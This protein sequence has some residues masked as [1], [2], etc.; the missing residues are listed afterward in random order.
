MKDSGKDLDLE[1]LLLK[2]ATLILRAINHPLRQQ[3]LR[4]LH[5]HGKMTVTQVYVKLRLEQ[6]V[7]SQQLAILRH[8]DFVIAEREGKFVWYAINYTRLRKVQEISH[9]LLV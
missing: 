6:S 9:K 5:Q 7:A 4:L 1:L 3:I 2:N 8:C